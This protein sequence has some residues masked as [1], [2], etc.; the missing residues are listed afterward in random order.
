MHSLFSQVQIG[1][2]T[3]TNRMVMAPMTRSR[4]D[5][6]GVPTELVPTYYAQ[7]AGAGLIISEGVFPVA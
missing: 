2:H 6:F 3:L 7:R 1:R 4:S 5:D